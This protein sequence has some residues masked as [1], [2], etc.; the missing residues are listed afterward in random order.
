[1][2]NGCSSLV[3]RWGS[4]IVSKAITAN[5]PYFSSIDGLLF[6]GTP[7]DQFGAKKKII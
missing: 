5:G 7:G 2:G 1:M 3:V 6:L 4:Q